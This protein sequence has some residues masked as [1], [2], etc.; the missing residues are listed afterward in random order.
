MWLQFIILITSCI[1]NFDYSCPAVIFMSGCF[2]FVQGECPLLLKSSN[3]QFPKHENSPLPPPKKE[4]KNNFLFF[5][6]INAISSADA[7]SVEKRQ[8]NGAR[9]ENGEIIEKLGASREGERYEPSFS[10]PSDP[11]MP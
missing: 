5:H 8:K 4:K 10:L 11:C 7:S 2:I 3:P 9:G 6:P 1:I